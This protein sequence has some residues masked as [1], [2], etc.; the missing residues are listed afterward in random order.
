M[1]E[2][3]AVIAPNN[4]QTGDVIEAIAKQSPLINRV[5]LLDKYQETRTFHIVYQSTTK[6]LTNEDIKPIREKIL[7]TLKEKFHAKLK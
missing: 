2:D 7:R 5:T 1:V 6:N 3:I 4:V